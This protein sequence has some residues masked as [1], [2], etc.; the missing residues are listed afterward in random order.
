MSEQLRET[1]YFGENDCRRYLSEEEYQQLV[2][3]HDKITTGRLGDNKMA[4][5][6]IFVR[7]G[8]AQY[9]AISMLY[10][11]SPMGDH[12]LLVMPS[13]DWYHPIN[14]LLLKR[15]R[16]PE[17]EA[18]ND[19]TQR[20]VATLHLLR[21]KY[22]PMI[23]ALARAIRK[24]TVD[25]ATEIALEANQFAD[26]ASRGA[27]SGDPEFAAQCQR[28]WEA[29]DEGFDLTMSALQCARERLL[30]AGFHLGRVTNT[31]YQHVGRRGFAVA[32]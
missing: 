4:V 12:P 9:P 30:E 20:S 6:G 27:A 25:A 16:G 17:Y 15:E 18:E 11:M 21:A 29:H 1:L 2:A 31:N 3:L 22:E 28:A 5:F 10:N 14:E 24:A 13:D 26:L 8:H 32:G 7:E 23:S 19:I